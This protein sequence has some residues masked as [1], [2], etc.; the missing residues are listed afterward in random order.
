M[1]WKILLYRNI[2]V[3]KSEEGVKRRLGLPCGSADKESACNAEDLGSVPGLG[4][5]AGEWNRCPLQ[6]SG[7]E[8]SM[9]CVFHGSQRFGHSWVTFTFHFQRGACQDFQQ[10]PK[11]K[12]M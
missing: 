7:L 6:Y 11:T 2:Y 10:V 4:R 3:K 8:Y 1:S 5:S 12:Q 9:D